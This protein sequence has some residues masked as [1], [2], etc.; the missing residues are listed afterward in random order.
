MQIVFHKLIR[1]HVEYQESQHEEKQPKRSRQVQHLIEAMEEFT[2]PFAFNNG[3][4]NQLNERNLVMQLRKL[5]NHLYLLLEDMESIPDELYYAELLKTSGK[6][7]V[8]DTLLDHLLE[9]QK[10]KVRSSIVGHN[11]AT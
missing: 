10:S 4:N 8:L 11:K 3:S 9:K 5:C 2:M 6:L 1:M 7:F